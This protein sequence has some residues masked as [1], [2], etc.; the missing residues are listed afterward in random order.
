MAVPYH[1]FEA[2]VAALADT[3]PKGIAIA[4]LDSTTSTNA[5]AKELSRE[6]RP[7]IVIARGQTS[8][9]GRLGRSF[10]SAMGEGIYLSYLFYPSIT[11]N[12][13][14]LLTASAAVATAECAE[15]ASGIRTGIKWV[16]DVYLGDK[17]IAGILTEGAFSADG[18]LE[19]AIIGVGLNLYERD[20]GDLSWKASSI[21][22][23]SG[24]H[25]DFAATLSDLAK[26][27]IFAASTLDTAG[28]KERSTVIGKR[29]LVSDP[30]GNYEATATDITD[31]CHLLVKDDSGNVHELSS[32]EISVITI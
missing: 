17:K 10:D 8:G 32:G 21:E 30:R 3:L 27:V 25:P 12:K 6:G 26:G 16:N 28:Y 29:V 23:E 2:A 15:R 24:R 14:S 18:R 5:L 4:A 20:F 9:R 7:T 1:E 13:I 11:P 31:E 22:S 19:Y